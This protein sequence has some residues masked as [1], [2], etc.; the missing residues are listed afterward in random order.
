MTDSISYLPAA[1]SLHP[2]VI[3]LLRSCALPVDDVSPAMEHFFVAMD[4]ERLVGT[5]GIE[6]L[7]EVA[8]FRSLA[9]VPDWRGHGLARQ[10]FEVARR[11]AAQLGLRELFLLTTTAEAIFARWGFVRIPREAAPASVQ[12]TPE[13]RTL[14]PGSAVVMRLA[15]SAADHRA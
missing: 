6:P 3:E 5:V 8:L 11:R 7:G 1:A 13:Y 10:L 9:V 2:E 14:C 12:A 15:V 4:G